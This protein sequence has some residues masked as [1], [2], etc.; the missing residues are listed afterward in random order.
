M[1]RFDLTKKLGDGAYG[2]VFKAT[3]LKTGEIVAIKKM[4]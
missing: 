3:N 1:E 2:S 4:K